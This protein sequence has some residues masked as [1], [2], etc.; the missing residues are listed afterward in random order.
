MFNDHAVGLVAKM[1]KIRSYFLCH[2]VDELMTSSAF[3]GFI[4]ASSLLAAFMLVPRRDARDLCECGEPQK[5]FS[6]SSIIDTDCGVVLAP[7]P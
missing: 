7:G 6:F 3:S 2:G 4:Q 5:N 1:L